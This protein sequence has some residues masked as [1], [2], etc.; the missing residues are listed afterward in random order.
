MVYSIDDYN[1]PNRLGLD[2]INRNEMRKLQR[3]AA[4]NDI[5]WNSLMAK[6]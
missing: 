5:K 1:G 4:S 6:S 2:C 3:L